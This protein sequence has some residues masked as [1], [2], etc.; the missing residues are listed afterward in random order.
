[1]GRGG[2]RS[3]DPAIG[4]SSDRKV[5]GKSRQRGERQSEEGTVVMRRPGSKIEK[6]R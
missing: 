3:G 6:P 4:T 2:R 1:M 5:I